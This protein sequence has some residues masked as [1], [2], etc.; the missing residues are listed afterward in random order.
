MNIGKVFAM[1]RAA[2]ATNASIDDAVTAAVAMYC[3]R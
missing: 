3:E 2:A 1:G